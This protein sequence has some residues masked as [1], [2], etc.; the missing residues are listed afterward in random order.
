[1]NLRSA[2]F[3]SIIKKCASQKKYCKRPAR[4]RKSKKCFERPQNALK[5]LPNSFKMLLKAF[6][7]LLK[8][9]KDFK[10][11][12][13]ML[14]NALKGLSNGSKYRKN[15]SAHANLGSVIL[16]KLFS[17]SAFCGSA[18]PKSRLHSIAQCRML[19]PVTRAGHFRYFLIFSITKGDFLHFLSS[20][21]DWEWAF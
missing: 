12:F 15:A 16:W 20:Y 3:G 21:F 14:Q 17:T 19:H 1:M 13:R 4:A 11:A 5:G 8:A 6:K 10:E 7:M 9:F 2:V 18:F